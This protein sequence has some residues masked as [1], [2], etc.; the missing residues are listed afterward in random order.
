MKLREGRAAPRTALDLAALRM[1][2]RANGRKS[3]ARP[4]RCFRIKELTEMKEWLAHLARYCTDDA[5]PE[6]LILEGLAGEQ[7]T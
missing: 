6:C 7:Q 5:H 1:R 3:T 2:Q 4:A